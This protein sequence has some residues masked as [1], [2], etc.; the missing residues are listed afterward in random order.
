MEE[1]KNCELN[2]ETLEGVAGG[3]GDWTGAHWQ[4]NG[5]PMGSVFE[6]MGRTWYRINSG[7]RLGAIALRFNIGGWGGSENDRALRGCYKL[8]EW[9]PATITNIN[10]IKAGD[11]LVI[12]PYG[13]GKTW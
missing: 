9:N 1:I 10:V 5:Q 4:G 2:A 12:R 8:Q 7:D 3:N 6:F 13:A 11:C